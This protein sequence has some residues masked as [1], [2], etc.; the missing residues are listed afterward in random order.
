MSTDPTD[1]GKIVMSAPENGTVTANGAGPR[2]E[3]TEPNN[4]FTFAG[5][6]SIK[7]TQQVV[8]LPSCGE[9]CI[10]Q[11]KGDSY[12]PVVSMPYLLSYMKSQVA[13][14]TRGSDGSSC[15]IVAEVVF[16]GRR[17]LVQTRDKNCN[18]VNTFLGNYAL[19]EE[20]RIQMTVRDFIV[21]VSS[22]KVAGVR[23]DYS[24]WKHASYGMRFKVGVYD[25]CAVRNSTLSG[26]TRLSGLSIVHQF[27]LSS[28]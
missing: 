5:N 16:D 28:S 9:V 3:L 14:L 2:T 1:N 22:N 25:Q 7:F 21:V 6:H 26:R 23:F 12:S 19:G 8:Q 15:L 20:I 18:N 13:Q 4:F 27:P 24:F 11:I 17:V 10:G